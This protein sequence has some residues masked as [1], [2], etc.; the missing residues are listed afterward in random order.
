MPT[1]RL[2]DLKVARAALRS[3]GQRGL[4]KL[5]SLPSLPGGTNILL[6]AF[7]VAIGL[8]FTAVTFLVL[9]A[10]QG[11]VVVAV[12][13]IAIGA[14]QFLW[15]LSQLALHGLK[16]TWCHIRLGNKEALRTSEYYDDSTDVGA[17]TLAA[18]QGHASAQFS[19]GTMY[20]E[21]RGV[22]R[23]YSKALRWLNRAAEQGNIQAQHNL[24][25]MYTE[26]KG[27]ARDAGRAFEWFHRAA[28]QGDPRAQ[29]NVGLH[30]LDGHGITGDDT[31][32]ANWFLRSAEQGYAVAQNNLGMMCKEGRT[33]GGDTKAVE[34]FRRAASRNYPLGLANLALMYRDGCGVAKDLG[35]AYVLLERSATR[36][37]QEAAVAKE[38][39]EK[40][41]S[42]EDLASAR[43][44]VPFT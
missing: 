24:G 41:M 34:W 10:W 28:Q 1:R 29:N 43:R 8:L 12:G 20:I 32:A 38:A 26:G 42:A 5:L 30:F 40:E 36:G 39:L 6:G 9:A 37:F 35:T 23:D 14:L 7:W 22:V 17:L 25:M 11:G 3:L 16:R 15:G 2:L 13:A 31:A 21:G 19:L 33:P 27:V 4:R 18:K 44:R